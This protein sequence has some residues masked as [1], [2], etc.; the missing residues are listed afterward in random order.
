M[1]SGA[2]KAASEAASVPRKYP[3]PS[4]AANAA[5]APQPT[6]V[7]RPSP[8]AVQ[9]P[10]P[11]PPP[12]VA[13]EPESIDALTPEEEAAVESWVLSPYLCPIRANDLPSQETFGTAASGPLLP[14]SSL[15]TWEQ[16]SMWERMCRGCVA[17]A[18]VRLTANLTTRLFATAQ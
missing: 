5:A 15:K 7:P 8:S 1:G 4:V 17:A 11:P 12:P 9:P 3:S 13:P 10:S 6:A 14:E 2:S 18:N 16:L